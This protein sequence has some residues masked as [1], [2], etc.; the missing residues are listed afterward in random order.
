VT[1][2]RIA[3]RAGEVIASE[4]DRFRQLDGALVAAPD[5]TTA[6][7]I[8]G[9]GRVLAIVPIAE[10]IDCA[11]CAARVPDMVALLAHGRDAHRVGLDGRRLLRAV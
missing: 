10:G 2:Y 11:L 6:H 9:R 8:P 4:R 7:T 3:C 5:L 1:T